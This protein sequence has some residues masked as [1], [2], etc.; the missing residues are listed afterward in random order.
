ML[1]KHVGFTG[2]QEGMTGAQLSRVRRIVASLY[3]WLHHGDCIGADA[4]AHDLARNKGLKVALHPPINPSKRAFCD[5]DL[6]HQEADYLT[7]NR[8]IV[9]VTD[10]LIACPKSFE[11]ELRS[12]TWSTVR[13]A[14]RLGK[15]RVIVYPDG[16]VRNER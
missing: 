5:A 14:R 3:G 6:I 1:E 16:S 2:T 11:E 8:A 10:G 7:R 13:Y 12:G 4:Q 15:P 9:N